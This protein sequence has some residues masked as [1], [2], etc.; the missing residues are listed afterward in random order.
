MITPQAVTQKQRKKARERYEALDPI[1]RK[2]VQMASI[3]YEPVPRATL[4]SCMD[5]LGLKLNDINKPGGKRSHT[6]ASFND[7]LIPLFR[8][9]L[10]ETSMMGVVCSDAI[11]EIAT[12]DAIIQDE[13]DSMVET[14]HHYMPVKQR[15]ST[16]GPRYFSSERQFIREVRIAL[17]KE[18]GIEAIETLFQEYYAYGSRS[19]MLSIT[20]CIN[21][22][23]NNPFDR[24]WFEN[25]DDVDLQETILT[26]I[27]SSSVMDLNDVDEA[28]DTLAA[29]CERDTPDMR[30]LLTYAD[31]MLI[32]GDLEAA[33]SVIPKLPKAAEE[34]G[35]PLNGAIAFLKG[36]NNKAIVLFRETLALYRKMT[37]KRKVYFRMPVGFL[38]VLALIK[39]GTPESLKEAM[40]HVTIAR[41]EKHWLSPTYNTIDTFLQIQQ[42]TF[43]KKAMLLNETP[44]LL[45]DSWTV[46]LSALCIYWSDRD[47]AEQRLVPGVE[48]LC[49]RARANG[50]LWFAMESAELLSR[51]TESSAPTTSTR[52]QIMADTLREGSDYE[53][54]VDLIAP[55]E[56]WEQSLVALTNLTGVM[57]TASGSAKGSTSR[58][59]WTLTP[60]GNGYLIQPKEQSLGAKGGW[61]KGRPIALKR[62]RT[63]TD[64]IPCLTPQ[65]LRICSSYIKAESY[66]GYYNKTEYRWSEDAILG[67]VGHPLVFLE[68]NPTTPIEVVKGSPE[69]V[70]SKMK[71]GKLAISFSPKLPPYDN[72]IVTKETP[73][74]IKIIEIT[75]DHRRINEILGS[76]NKLEVPESAKEKVLEAI[77]SISSLVT[78][79]SDIGG[80]M[81]NA[82]EVPPISTPHIHLLPSGEG[83]RLSIL[84]APFGSKG[85]SYYRPGIGG[86]T[87]IAEVEGKRLQ[88]TRDIKAEKKLTKEAIEACP[89]LREWEE[90]Q[91]EWVIETAEASLE[92]LLQL[93]ELGEKAIVE[94]PQG[95]KMRISNTA[96]FGNLHMKLKSQNEWFN[97]SGELRLP[98][99]S[100]LEMQNLLRLLDQSTGRFVSLGDG[101][102]LALTN[103]FRRR[104]EELRDYS[105]GTKTGLRFNKL[106]APTLE[107]WID[108][109]G[110]MESDKAWKEQMARIQE[111][112]DY[113]PELPSTLQAELR[114]YQIEG[115]TWLARLAKW[116][117]GACLADDMGLGKTLQTLALMLVRAPQGPTLAIAPTSVCMNWISEAQKFA[118]T[119]NP[120]QFGSG[121]RQKALDDLQPFDLVVCSYGLLQQ[122]EVA[123]MLA[124]VQW[125][126]IVLDE[127]Q[128]IKNFATKRSQAAMNLQGEFKLLTT[129]TPIENHLGELWN[130]FRFIN[131]GLLGSLDQFNQRYA[132]AIERGLD[133]KV[134]DRLRKLI[135]PFIL[136]RTKTQVLQELPSRTEI[137]LNA[138]LSKEE[139]VFYEALRR[140]V[141]AKLEESDVPA[142]QKHL[143]VL[144]EIMRLR[145]ACCNTQLVKPEIAIPS[146]KLEVFANITTELLDNNHKAL[147]FSQF[148]DH[149]ALIRAYLD[150][151]NISY[152]YLD[153][154]TPMKERKK[155]VDAFQAGEG[156]IFLI[157]LKAGGTGLNLTA[158][159]Y[160][161]HMDPWWNPAVEDQASDRAHRM[162]QKRPVTIYRIVAK[163]TIEEKIVQLHQ[164]KRE[165]ADS[166][167]EGTELSAKMQT[168]DLIRLIQER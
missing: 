143:Q 89:T 42:G 160:V 74:R 146:S 102:F 62:L 46:L 44:G 37:G 3:I 54:I 140:E 85:G 84:V 20:E 50:F 101:Q 99:G 63:A 157:S 16:S 118:P 19:V 108:D 66:G 113:Q 43:S 79:Q 90:V 135:Q 120:I 88:T 2:V 25:L 36:D 15:F 56:A 14:L 71:G 49:D 58:V 106:T 22:I 141:I 78:V 152:Q 29:R 96:G 93:R 158:A 38:F 82:E 124:K 45:G 97:A 156:D 61:N 77:G 81:S 168:D 162:G 57:P 166:L 1:A 111:L 133:K 18:E 116:G 69:L 26:T 154:S 153:G 122:E 75:T 72:T 87:V 125:Q 163:D 127:A 123:E 150:E 119:L 41:K 92:L 9:T 132:N 4:L 24:D 76:K 134:R 21:T 128:S 100:V 131:P 55:Q 148:V 95:E 7:L 34:V 138:E 114:D 107:D 17:Y 53:S 130:L 126:T 52:W 137:V 164:Q 5:T 31:L 28:I 145:R 33:Q 94:W 147:V 80:G 60:M 121:N 91:G 12:R 112:R 10:L 30:S 167:L 48:A 115:F 110:S 68:A 104:L 136:R 109:I 161:I 59:I 144:A 35:Y 32:R 155:R 73:T 67:L 159:D 65:D 98:D 149:L 83:L 11:V 139:M 6:A 47:E 142:G 86:E 117:V 151:N 8:S 51:L 13:F 105:E 70:V 39:D 23:V 64:E 129:G 103:E 165:L 40:E 27:V